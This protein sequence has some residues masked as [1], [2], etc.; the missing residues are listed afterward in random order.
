LTDVARRNARV[1]ANRRVLPEPNTAT[2]VFGALAGAFPGPSELRLETH[3]LLVKDIVDTLLVP[4]NQAEYLPEIADPAV[5]GAVIRELM[6]GQVLPSM[7]ADGA[8]T[9]GGLSVQWTLGMSS[10]R[11]S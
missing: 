2:E 3:E 7:R 5:R 11:A 8:G 10:N 9:A 6:L 4:S 1:R